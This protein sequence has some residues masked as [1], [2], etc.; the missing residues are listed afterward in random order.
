M[1]KCVQCALTLHIM[2]VET[3]MFYRKISQRSC[4]VQHCTYFPYLAI[5]YMFNIEE[6]QAALSTLYSTIKKSILHGKSA[7]SMRLHCTEC[8]L[9]HGCFIT[10]YDSDPAMYS[11]VP[12]SL[13]LPSFICSMKKNFKLHY[14]RYYLL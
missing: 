13:I 4:H 8:A 2:H 12:T 14:Q 7:Y 5:Y 11:T 10:L 6:F 1:E 3:R 9:K